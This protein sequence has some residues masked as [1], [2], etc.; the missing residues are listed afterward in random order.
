MSVGTGLG[1]GLFG[2]FRLFS[3]VASGALTLNGL[4]LSFI[5]LAGSVWAWRSYK[6]YI[7]ELGTTNRS[8]KILAWISVFI[9][10][11]AVFFSAAL[12]VS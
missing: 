12:H 5:L 4:I 8:G 10:I 11:V 1:L 2:L 6:G 9:V 3:L 7:E